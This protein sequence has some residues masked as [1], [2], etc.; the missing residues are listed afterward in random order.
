[1]PHDAEAIQQQLDGFLNEIAKLVK[2]ESVLNEIRLQVG[3][4]VS[5]VDSDRRTMTEHGQSIRD[6]EALVKGV[7]TNGDIGDH[8]RVNIMWKAHIWLIGVGGT[9]VGA[10]GMA[11]YQM[12]KSKL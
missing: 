12:I 9:V 3:H 10:I 7:P 5:I 8:H 4:L 1:M 6:L 11:I 2:T